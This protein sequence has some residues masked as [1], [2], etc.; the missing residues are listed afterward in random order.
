MRGSGG[1][2]WTEEADEVSPESLSCDQGIV[3]SESC[4]TIGAIAPT[5][6]W[7]RLF[8]PI[9]KTSPSI[10]TQTKK[11]RP[12]HN[13]VRRGGRPESWTRAGGVTGWNVV[14]GTGAAGVFTLAG[15]STNFVIS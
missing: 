7:P 2:G 13:L 6:S 11:P 4:S 5:P 10:V 9:A 12:A 15:A 8:A 1:R 3:T 14:S